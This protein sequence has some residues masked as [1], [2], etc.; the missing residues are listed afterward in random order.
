MRI[1][2]ADLKQASRIFRQSPAFAF[3]A[4]AALTLG[5]GANTA[6]FSVFNAVVL[7]PLNIPQADR[8]VEFMLAFPGGMNSTGSPQHFFVWHRQTNIFENV[9]AHRLELVNL[10]DGP[11]P[12]QLA[13]A[14][15]T[16]DFFSLFDAPILF[17]RTFSQEEDRPNGGRVVVL[18]HAVWSSRFASDPSIV[19]KGIPLNGEQYVVIG[20]LG[21]NFNTE[22]FDQRPATWIPFQIDP[23]ST[24]GG[25]YC[26]VTGRLK[27]GVTLGAANA[28]LQSVSDQYRHDFPKQLGPK[29][30]FHVELLRDVMVGNVRSTFTILLGAV[31]FVL[32]IACTN[33]ANLLLVRATS[34][35][36]EIAIRVA[37]GASRTRII[38]QLVTESIVLSFAGGVLGL[39]L[40]L[41]AI[42][43]LLAS[44]SG[45][46]LLGRLNVINIPRLGEHG[47]A[48]ALD[49]RVLSFTLLVSLVTG[50][51]FG[52]FPSI[53]A[54]R[55]DLNTVL[56]EN[57]GRSGIGP[58]QNSVRAILVVSEMAL[59][60]I[61][62]VGASL[63]IRTAI[64]LRAVD[65][66][67]RSHN[68]LVMQMSLAGKRFERTFEIDG[69]VR[70]GIEQVHSVPGV[71]AAAVSCCV[72]LETVWQLSF[73]VEG[74]PLNGP[75]HGFAGWTFISPEYFDAFK[76]PV[77]RGRGITTR[78]V[79]GSPGVVV[80]NQ[81]MARRY[82][83]N[84]DPLSDQLIIGR[85][86][87]PEYEKDR[88][89][90][91]VGVVGDIR[92]VGLSRD[93]RPAMYIPISQLP[94]GVNALNLRLLPV[95]WIVRSSVD[96]NS[97]VTP[98]KDRLRDGTALPVTQVRS[99]DEI[100]AQSTART[101]LNMVL[102]TTFGLSAL[103]LAAIG[104]YGVMAYSVQQ[105][106]QEIGIRVALGATAGNVRNMIIIYG[107]RLA[108][109]GV[110]IGVVAALGL[111]R[112]LQGLLFGVKAWDPAVLVAV[113]ILMTAV[114]FVSV[115]LPAR[116]ATGINPIDAIRYE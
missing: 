12:Q 113:P 108:V 56:K 116:R 114:S 84:S 110:F 107:M 64:A 17:G 62:L 1:A 57:A 53:S 109:T 18:S 10:T 26:R 104:I 102:M 19:G 2:F 52:L 112:L 67:F 21:A 93:P 87:R 63:L 6:I 115:W 72:P 111:A 45:N 55:V 85:S 97:L 77:L 58:R 23:D 33:V 7:K 42:R 69:L 35:R 31:G 89:R 5:I 65:P 34:R 94:D 96:P 82:W 106:T 27:P 44:Y 32:L 48:I 71:A 49:W 38:R 80:I 20:I 43:A 3:A 25:C 61:L 99:M 86:V 51:L 30:S 98:L 95:A 8:L 73:V 9:S 39:G 60:L 76:I 54:S 103:L 28:E 47:S 79:A 78:D 16:A 46:P 74:R 59:A 66:G 13:A 50:L 83:P 29:M 11:D 75:F 105:R 68:V 92:D 81:A 41:T 24:E 40:G 36:R 4:V 37:V 14:R 100:V 15:V 88:P 101:R 70:S 22:Q 90:Q 91:I